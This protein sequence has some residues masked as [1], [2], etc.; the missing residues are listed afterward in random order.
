MAEMLKN[1]SVF[2][3]DRNPHGIRSFLD[4]FLMYLNRLIFTMPACDQQPFPVYKGISDLF[5]C[6]FINGGYS[7][8]GNIH[9]GCTGFLG[10]AFVI[11]K[12]QRLKLVNGHQYIFRGCDIIRRKASIDWKLLYSAASEWSWH[13]LSFLTYVNYY[14]IP[15]NGICQ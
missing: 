14:D 4:N 12:P 5:P 6:T 3:C 13:S 10:K 7:S 8:P 2:V 9:P 11:Q 15:I 1:L